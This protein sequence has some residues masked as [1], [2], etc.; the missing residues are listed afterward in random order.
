M[1]YLQY[2]DFTSDIALASRI[3]QELAYGNPV[4]LQGAP[5][6][7]IEVTT[8]SIAEHLAIPPGRVFQALSAY[9]MLQGL[10]YA[11]GFPDAA[12]RGVINEFSHVRQ[13]LT[14][15]CEGVHDIESVKCILDCPLI[16]PYTPSFMK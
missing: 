12:V 3:D 1:V 5:Y 11:D 16:E 10:S 6:K 13:T 8:E 9:S 7:P 15:F 4:V 2:K 14:T